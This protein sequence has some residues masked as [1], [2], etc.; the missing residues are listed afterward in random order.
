MRVIS[1]VQEAVETRPSSTRPRS[2]RFPFLLTSR[3]PVLLTGLF[4]SLLGIQASDTP[5]EEPLPVLYFLTPGCPSCRETSEAVREAEERYGPRLQ[6]TRHDLAKN[7]EA[8]R[9][10]VVLL[11]RHG[12]VET[13]N[14]AVFVGTEYLLGAKQILS[15]LSPLLSRRLGSGRSPDVDKPAV[16]VP[17]A[18][19]VN[20][21]SLLLVSL[22]ALADGVNPCAFATI[23]LF[24]SMLVSLGRSRREILLMGAS[25]LL[26]TFL[27]YLVIG[28]L[29]YRAMELLRGLQSL[30]SVI[31]YGAM[32]FLGVAALLSFRDAWVALLSGGRGQMALVLP[33]ALKNNIRSRLRGAARGALLPVFGA[34][35]VVTVI[36]SACTGQVYFPLI[37]GLVENES[38]FLRGIC[39]LLWYNVLFLIPLFGVF[40][41]VYFGLPVE[42]IATSARRWAWVFKL[43]LGL[44]FAALAV[45]LS[46]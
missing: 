33:E 44:V 23:I 22:A 36:E 46:L 15:G 27:T 35:V 34:G 3:W 29:F 5:P 10:Y 21:T 18:P 40:L 45:W 19:G 6:V 1:A 4:L 7:E 12:I 31:R 8:F 11:D 41:L 39:L 43:A 42:R 28:L 30:S 20:R 14:L 9:D 37:L 17:V 16:E 32:L 13:P 26:A 24:S 38:T 25:F 2:W